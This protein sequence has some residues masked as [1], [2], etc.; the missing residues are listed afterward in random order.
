MRDVVQKRQEE[1]QHR[2]IQKE[3]EPYVSPLDG[4]AGGEDFAHGTAAC[5]LIGC[6]V[7]ELEKPMLAFPTPIGINRDESRQQF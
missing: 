6:C 5:C 1:Q 4:A 3:L 2:S 7:T